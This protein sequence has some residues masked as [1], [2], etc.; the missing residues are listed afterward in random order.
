[1]SCRVII[2]YTNALFGHGLQ[3]LL[4]RREGFEVPVVAPKDADLATAVREHRPDVI[5]VEGEGLS[6]ANARALLEAAWGEP[7]VRVVNIR[8]DP[9]Q[10]TVWRAVAVAPEGQ[11]SATEALERA[12]T[13]G[14]DPA[15]R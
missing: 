13:A 6:P 7:R 8:D 15:E 2:L 14:A 10:P 9:R 3:S 4:A 1:M 11:E 12:L 5:I